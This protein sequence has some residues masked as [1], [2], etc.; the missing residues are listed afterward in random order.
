M[1]RRLAAPVLLSAILVA[2]FAGVAAGADPDVV[3]RPP[4]TRDA[5]PST[6]DESP[7]VGSGRAP[8]T[9]PG[10]NGRIAFSR[11][12]YLLFPNEI[13]SMASNGS[14]Q[15]QLTPTVGD[16]EWGDLWP[17]YSP[18]GTMIAFTRDMVVGADDLEG[19]IFVMQT[20]GTGLKRLTTATA[21]DSVP[22]WTPDGS[23]LVFTSYRT[24]NGDIYSMAIDGTDV[25]RL[26]T[27]A[28]TDSYPSVSPDGTR[29]AFASDRQGGDLDVYTMNLD[30]SGVSLAL[31]P[32]PDDDYQPDWSP[33]GSK[34]TFTSFQTGD[35][36]VFSMNANGSIPTN[37]TN[38]AAFEDFE[39]SW[40]PDGTK[41]AFWSY[42]DADTDVY[43]MAS[44]GSAQTAIGATPN[45]E[46]GPDWQP[47]P[48]FPLVDARFS[49]FESYIEW[50]YEEGI[51][52]GCSSERY[53]P[54][55]SVTREQMASF[56][57][58][59]LHLSGP[60]PDAFTDDET[61]VHEVN[62]N[63]VAREG[64]A[65]GCG[66]NLFCPSGLVKR[67]QMASFLSR[68]LDLSGP[69]PNAFIDDNGNLHEVNINLVAREGI[70]TGCG[71]NLYC[72]SANVTRGQM[73]AFLYRAFAP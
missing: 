26:T 67:D 39:P 42:S 15:Q 68:A 52:S 44:N 23:R 14:D 12:P 41:I 21:N 73:A 56:L 33:D 25:R 36:E 17:A 22:D 71:V 55:A 66:V 64:I 61:S 19:D 47:L 63:L 3:D 34:I 45:D 20:N 53:C 29:I 16:D 72:P 7:K 58:R 65:S 35:A 11:S 10:A 50:V 2:S 40:S 59:A 27:N 9:A 46:W 32:D 8:Q 5:G 30:G 13:W 4:R 54:D 69:A 70:A 1:S 31:T 43:V 60:A 38:D 62:I 49:P 28:A 37:L 48:D 18:G 6:G 24:G 51:T 57:A